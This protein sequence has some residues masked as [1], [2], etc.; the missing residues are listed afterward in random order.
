MSLH[1]HCYNLHPCLEQKFSLIL[2]NA[3][4]SLEGELLPFPY[5]DKNKELTSGPGSDFG[6]AD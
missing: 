2:D 4:A 5:K 3:E 1:E 6:Y